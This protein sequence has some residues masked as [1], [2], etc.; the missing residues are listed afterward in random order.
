MKIEFKK[1]IYKVNDVTETAI[2]YISFSNK[3]ITCCIIFDSYFNLNF[4]YNINYFLGLSHRGL[5][6]LEQP[7]FHFF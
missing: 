4:M 7:K 5:S 6:L 3:Y 1:N 2:T